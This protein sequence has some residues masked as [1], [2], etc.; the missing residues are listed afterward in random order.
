MRQVCYHSLSTT[1]LWIGFHALHGDCAK[2]MTTS[3]HIYSLSLPEEHESAL[4]QEAGK[5]GGG[6]RERIRAKV[7]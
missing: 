3:L 2:V 7:K 6:V 1:A 4:G 5:K